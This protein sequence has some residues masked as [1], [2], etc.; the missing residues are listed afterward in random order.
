MVY[1]NISNNLISGEKTTPQEMTAL[2]FMYMSA[3]TKNIAILTITST[4]ILK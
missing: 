3:T 2:I 4:F 1:E